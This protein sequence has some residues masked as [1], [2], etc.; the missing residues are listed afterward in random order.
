MCPPGPT[1]RFSVLF[2][3]FPGSPGVGGGYKTEAGEA[4]GVFLA[5]GQKHWL[6]W[7]GRQQL[8][9]PVENP[10]DAIEVPYPA[11]GAVRPP[12]AEPLRY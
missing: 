2:A 7:I 1:K 5:L 11:A 9:Q 3:P 8:R 6:G 10:P 4:V 12:L